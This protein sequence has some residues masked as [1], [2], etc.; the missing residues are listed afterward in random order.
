MNTKRPPQKLPH[1]IL[2]YQV[3][4]EVIKTSRNEP[5]NSDWHLNLSLALRGIRRQRRDAL[6]P[7][8]ANLYGLLCPLAFSWVLTMRGT[9]RR[10]KRRRRMESRY[11]SPQHAP[12]QI[13]SYWL[14]LSIKTTA[15]VRKPPPFIS[16]L[17]A[18]EGDMAP[19]SCLP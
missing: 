8:E 2:K 16:S 19:C 7:P 9:S 5:K 17:R 6:C 11:L 1:E 15:P 12:C 3:S 4:G 14:C 10:L 18:S 13:T